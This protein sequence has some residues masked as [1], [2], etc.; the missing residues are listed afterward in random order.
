MKY[1]IIRAC[2]IAG[3]PYKVGDTVELK[4][5]V[6]RNLIAIERVVPAQEEPEIVDRSV[7]LET[8]E[9]KPKKRGR[10]KKVV[11]DDDV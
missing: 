10:P 3:K 5:E 6:A 2:M 11:P 4:P 9:D 8:S 7:G 1:S